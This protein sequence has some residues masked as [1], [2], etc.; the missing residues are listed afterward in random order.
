[1]FSNIPSFDHFAYAVNFLKYLKTTDRKL[2]SVFGYYFIK[3]HKEYYSFL[4]GEFV[5]VHISKN[6]NQYDNVNVVNH[7]NQTY[8]FEFG[9]QSRLPIIEE[10]FEIPQ[11][12]FKSYSHVI[13]II[14]TLADDKLGGN[15]GKDRLLTLA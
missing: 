10:S 7:Q 12:D 14:P 13:N 15:F 6:D 4:V 1:T 8:L 5:K 2:P 11:V 9:K 3:M